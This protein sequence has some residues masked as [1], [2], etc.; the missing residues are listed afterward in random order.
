[1][2]ITVRLL[3]LT[4]AITIL[5]TSIGFADERTSRWESDAFSFAVTADMRNFTPPEYTG[6]DYFEGVCKSLKAAGAGEFMVAV[7]DIDPPARVRAVLDNVF[8]DQYAWYPVTG[9]HEAET[10]ADME[11]LRQWGGGEVPRLVRS[12]PAGAETTTYSFDH[13]RA[14]FVVL[15]QYYNGSS[16]TGTDGDV[17]DAL[18]SWL[19]LDLNANRKPVVFVFGHEPVVAIPDMETGRIRHTG[20]S[21]D[22]Y[23]ERNQRF[24][25]LLKRYDVEVYFCGHTHNASFAN[26]NGLWQIDAGHS[27]GK[28][29]PGAPSTFLK[30]WVSSM[31][32]WIEFFRRNPAGS[33]ELTETVIIE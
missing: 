24:Q 32:V 31:H 25:N 30:A 20:D 10:P 22:Q 27:R 19:K 15:N 11:F 8:G 1:M 18:Y 14:H 29:D 9:N 17:E 2:P 6:L 5:F 23:P 33:Y 12:G 16:D 13:G 4:S 28:G 7:G 26:I 3:T 21:L